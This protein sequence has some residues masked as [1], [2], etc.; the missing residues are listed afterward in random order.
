MLHS[1]SLAKIKGKQFTFLCTSL[2]R[3]TH[4]KCYSFWFFLL[5]RAICSHVWYMSLLCSLISLSWWLVDTLWSH[6]AEYLQELVMTMSKCHTKSSKCMHTFWY[7]SIMMKRN[8]FDI[9]TV[10]GLLIWRLFLCTLSMTIIQQFIVFY[11][12]FVLEL[13]HLKKWLNL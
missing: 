2:L 12:D 1:V 3:D 5:T 13:G 9:V 11:N 8:L 7:W 10:E 6:S 4:L